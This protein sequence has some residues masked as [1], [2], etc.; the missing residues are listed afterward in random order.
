MYCQKFR[1]IF[2]PEF[3]RVYVPFETKDVSYGKFIFYE[4]YFQVFVKVIPK[5]SIILI[6]QERTCKYSKQILRIIFYT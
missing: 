6:G 4:W 5:I 3:R 1:D 2:F